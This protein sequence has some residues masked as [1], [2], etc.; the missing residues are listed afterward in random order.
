VP[1][2]VTEWLAVA[3]AAVSGVEAGHD[4]DTPP[5]EQETISSTVTGAALA[6]ADN[7]KQANALAVKVRRE[8][9]RIDG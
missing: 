3:I 1:I 6:L 4:I 9:D 5:I 8:I 7:T 2:P